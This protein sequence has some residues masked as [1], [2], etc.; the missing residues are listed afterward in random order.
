MKNLVCVF[1][2]ITLL[3]SCATEDA[4]T[5][6]NPDLSSDISPEINTE[7]I[8]SQKTNF[9][10]PTADEQLVRFA[11]IGD[12]T[13]GE[14]SGVFN[15]GAQSIYAMKPDFIMSIGDLIEGGTEDIAKMDKEWSTF[16]KN[17]N[18]RDLEFYP[19]VGNHDIS[20][21]VMRQ[22]YEEKVGPRYYHFVYKNAL[23]LVLDSEDFTD[24]FF[25]ELKT[26]RNDAIK[27]YKKDPRD[28]AYTEYA[29]MD[30][31]KFGEISAEQKEYMVNAIK[32]N[33]DVRWTFLFMHKPVWQDK[34][35][36]HFKQIEQALSESDYTVFNGHVH[37]YEHTE[38]LGKDYI[39]LATTGGEM[40]AQSGINMDHIMWV[41]LKDKTPSYLNIKL[42]GMINKEGKVPA[43]GDELCL[44]SAGCN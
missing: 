33:Q 22:W 27:V 31:R 38:R 17:L 39:Q 25:E 41:A 36:Q 23:F 24:V 16:N 11:I 8:Q 3:I 2:S 5:D 19:T 34:K 37:S 32:E 21:N 44:N 15:V 29:Q 26:K 4:S 10:S 7:S 30:E 9:S 13:G 12:L 35:E 1:C 14:R 20:N 42:N 18:N 40:N 43:G 28:F 6:I